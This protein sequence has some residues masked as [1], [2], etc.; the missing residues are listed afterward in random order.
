MR[1]GT[2][3]SDPSTYAKR[4]HLR[5]IRQFAKLSE[6]SYMRRKPT[7]IESPPSQAISKI[8]PS[9]IYQPGKKSLPKQSISEIFE[10]S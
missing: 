5:R 2:H 1:I 8:S 9:L 3:K 10:T 4:I 6:L 7:I